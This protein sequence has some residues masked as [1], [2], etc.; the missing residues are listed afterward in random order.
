MALELDGYRVIEASNGQTALK[1]L[2]NLEPSNYPHC[3]LLDQ[4]MPVMGG[5]SFMEILNTSYPVRFGKIPIILCSAFGDCIETPQIFAKIE[6]PISL[7]H[8]R[9]VVQTALSH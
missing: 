9:N 4:M 3:I 5:N 2:L 1:L 6:K 8:L 7:E